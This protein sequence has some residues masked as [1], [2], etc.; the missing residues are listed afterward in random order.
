MDAVEVKNITTNASGLIVKRL[1]KQL[2]CLTG[3]FLVSQSVQSGIKK[4]P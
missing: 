1:P 4:P 2:V 3:P